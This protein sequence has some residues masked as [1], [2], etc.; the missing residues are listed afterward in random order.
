MKILQLL[1]LNNLDLLAVGIAIAAIGILGFVVYFNN[2][3][4]ITNKTFLIF[5]FLTAVYGIFNY[6]NYKVR[7]PE[8]ILWFLRLTIFSAVWHAFALFQFFYVFPK[9]EVKFSKWYKKIL[10]PGTIIT[11]IL[12][13]TPLVFNR[14]DKIA[15]EG[16]VTNP[17][18]GPAIA[19]FG[20]AVVFLVLGSLVILW[21]KRSAAQKLERQQYNTIAAGTSITFLLILCF[22]FFLPVV[23]NNLKFIPLAPVFILPFIAFTA[24]AIVRYHLLNAKII[25]TE[26]LTFLLAIS[27]LFEVLIS[28]DIQSAAFRFIIFF[29]ILNI[30]FLLNK[31]VRNE[32]EQKDQL[33]IL[34]TQLADANEK[35]KAL[36]QARSEFITIA[37]HQLRTPPA[38]I[39]W[40]LSAVLA[41]DFGKLTDEQKNVIDKAN[42]TNN[43]QISL[44]DDMLNVSRIERGKMEFLFE[45]TDALSLADITI[46][47]L[48]PM[49]KEKNL[50]LQFKRP[51]GFLPKIMADKEKL[52]Q[53]MNNLIDN[54]LKYTKQ[55]DINV[56]LEQKNDEIVF[57]VKDTG[58]G[59]SKE[60]GEEIFQKFKRGNES[61]KQSAGL[62]LGLYVAKVIIEQHKGKI[63]AESQG[64]GKGSVFAFSLPV[65]TDL[66]A[67]TLLD[68]TK[69]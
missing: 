17:E 4:S 52:R 44:I 7:S 57:S 32:I 54:A 45:E 39:K 35:L 50:N 5:A 13:L 23:F 46:E 25:T 53:V 64:Q 29:L 22:N 41:G 65:H 56:S 38:T 66:H 36:D 43:S 21:K 59:F 19:L 48:T 55:G 28:E 11:S 34:S 18:R 68:L 47:Q 31:S 9:E 1:N 60:E 61:V 40:Y 12:T 58:K 16:Q 14:I 67:T 63:W 10:I 3:K 15:V 2:K 51:S 6:I 37:S 49:S 33:Q 62:G 69:G 27:S 26:F 42:R 20:I 24:V 30:S 8:L